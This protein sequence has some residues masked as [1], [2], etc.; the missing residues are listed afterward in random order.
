MDGVYRLD[1]GALLDDFFHFLRAIGV[2]ALLADV[3]GTAIHREMVPFV[4]DYPA[5]GAEDLVWH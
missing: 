3:P 5:L 1:E 2:I 4:Q